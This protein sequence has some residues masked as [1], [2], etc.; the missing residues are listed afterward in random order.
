V[1][2]HFFPAHTTGIEYLVLPRPGMY[3][4]MKVLWRECNVIL[5]F[6]SVS[7]GAP[8]SQTH[9]LP[10]GT[11]LKPLRADLVPLT[12]WSPGT[13]ERGKHLSWVHRL[14]AGGLGALLSQALVLVFLGTGCIPSLVRFYMRVSSLTTE[15][16]LWGPLL[17]ISVLWQM[18]PHMAESAL[19]R[20]S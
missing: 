13:T 16:W 14:R 6:L 7:K 20:L 12:W 18:M 1:T 9:A 5:L 17:S 15:P 4:Q 8:D 11:V 2:P 3:S 19:P 10:R